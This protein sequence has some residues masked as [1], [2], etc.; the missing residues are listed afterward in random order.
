MDFVNI[1]VRPDGRVSRRDA[2]TYLGLSSKALAN[3][4]YQGKGPRSIKVAGRRF[5]YLND[6]AAFVDGQTVQ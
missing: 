1:T 3:M 4:G 6:L 5:Y 2:A